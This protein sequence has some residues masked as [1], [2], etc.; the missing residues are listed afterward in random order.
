[1]S[2]TRRRV[3]YDDT[4]KTPYHKP[5]SNR[6]IDLKGINLRDIESIYETDES[7]DEIVDE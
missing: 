6:L 3:K 7:L 5:K 4:P 1:M 2:N